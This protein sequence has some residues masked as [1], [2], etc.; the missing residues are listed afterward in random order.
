MDEMIKKH[1]G[2]STA[3]SLSLQNEIEQMNDFQRRNRI[4]DINILKSLTLQ[5]E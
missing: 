4:E 1:A 3:F 2:E 5:I